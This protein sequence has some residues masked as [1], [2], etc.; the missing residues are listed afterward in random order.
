MTMSRRELSKSLLGLAAASSATF[1]TACPLRG[2]FD[3]IL[4]Y[5]PVALIAFDRVVSIAQ[6]S[7][8]DLSQLQNV[9][10][11]VKAALADIQTAIL[12][13]R[14]HDGDTLRQAIL[15]ALTIAHQR[16]TEFASAIADKLSANTALAVRALLE[17]IIST[18]NGFQ[19]QISRGSGS[20][21]TLAAFRRDFNAKLPDHKY[22]I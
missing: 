5:V 6:D 19:S 10:A 15:T 4:R 2:K 20:V 3:N 12:E 17:V 14:E 13:F 9:I 21:P 16:L 22:D 1:D 7:G 8:A 11:R 18:L